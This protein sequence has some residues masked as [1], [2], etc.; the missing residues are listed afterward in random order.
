VDRFAGCPQGVAMGLGLS[1]VRTTL[2]LGGPTAALW[3]VCRLFGGSW[4]GR[5]CRDSAGIAGGRLSAWGLRLCRAWSFAGLSFARLGVSADL[6]LSPG[7]ELCQLELRQ[8]CTFAD[9]SFA[10]LEVSPG[11]EL[12]PGMTLRRPCLWA[13]G[14]AVGGRRTA[15]LS[16]LARQAARDGSLRAGVAQSGPWRARVPLVQGNNH[17]LSVLPTTLESGGPP[18]TFE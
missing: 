2:D 8:A 1:V 14:R 3:P 13:R 10:R 18:A 7:M 5:G 17:E 12:S 9:L 16:V 15:G 4:R 6:E 11:L